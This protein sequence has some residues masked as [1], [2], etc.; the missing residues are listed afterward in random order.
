MDIKKLVVLT[1]GTAVLTTQHGAAASRVTHEHARLEREVRREIVMLPQYSLFDHFAFRVD[2]AVVT[3]IGKVSQPSLK[4]G[5]EAVV[6]KIEGV[7]RVKNEIVVLPLSAN[8]DR[9]RLALYHSIYGHGAL[10][11]LALRAAPPIHIIVENG[12]VTLEG[13]VSSELEKTV[14]NAQ[15]NS[16]SGVFSVTNNLR[17]DKNG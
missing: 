13:A 15:A 9:L 4:S 5:A 6:S 8:D 2:G 3:L 10:Q 12:H 14:A 1:M 16:V 17:V 11:T 7:E